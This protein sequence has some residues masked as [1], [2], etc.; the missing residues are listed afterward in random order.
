[1]NELQNT[2]TYTWYVYMDDLEI[3]NFFNKS[4]II[5]SEMQAVEKSA[6]VYLLSSSCQEES[7]YCRRKEVS[8]IRA[9]YC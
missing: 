4:I 9:Y 7:I 6:K 3:K 5:N 8:L 2:W 1:M